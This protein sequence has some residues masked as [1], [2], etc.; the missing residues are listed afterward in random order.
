VY[1]RICTHMLLSIT[2]CLGTLFLAWLTWELKPSLRNRI[3][4]VTVGIVWMFLTV[5]AGQQLELTLADLPR[6]VV[7][8]ITAVK[9]TPPPTVLPAQTAAP[10]SERR[11]AIVTPETE[12][13]P[14]LTAQSGVPMI[15]LDS[16]RPDCLATFSCGSEFAKGLLGGTEDRIGAS[17]EYSLNGSIIDRGLAQDSLNRLITYSSLTQDPLTGLTINGLTDPLGPNPT[18]LDCSPTLSCT[19]TPDFRIRTVDLELSR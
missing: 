13:T 15:G 10:Q 9:S 12:S 2:V 6:R 19:S 14:V 16:L 3:A 5:R 18:L 7:E 8:N 11:P 1:G 4:F 17:A